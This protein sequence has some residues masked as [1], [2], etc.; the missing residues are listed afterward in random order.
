MSEGES[1]GIPRG[2]DSPRRAAGRRS[3]EGGR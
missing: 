2:P 1:D 3:A